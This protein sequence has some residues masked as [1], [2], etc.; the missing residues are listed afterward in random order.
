ME[1]YNINILLKELNVSENTI[2]NWIKF[3]DIEYDDDKKILSLNDY[4]KIK[5]Y[6]KNNKLKSRANKL[7]KNEH[8][9]ND[10]TDIINKKLNDNDINNIGVF[11]ENSLSNSYKNKEGIYYTPNDII[12]DF[13]IIDEDI[14][15]KKFCDPCCGSGNFIMKA[16]SLGFKPENIYG[17]DIDPIA[18]DITKKRILLET[19]YNSENIKCENFLYNEES[20]EFDYI[21]TNPPWGK[22]ISKDEKN[23][24]NKKFNINANDTCVMFYFVILQRLKE[25]GKLGLILPDSF[26]N[27]GSFRNARE[28]ILKYD[29]TSLKHYGQPFEELA[30]VGCVGFTLIKNEKYNEY[31]NCEYNKNKF[32][33]TR[34]SF[35]KNPKTIFNLN[36]KNE[37][38]DIIEYIL[39]RDDYITLEN[40]A[41]WGLGIMTGN[42]NKFITEKED[43]GYTPIF[44]GCDLEKDNIKP[45]SRYILNDLSKCQQVAPIDMYM[46][47]EKII[48]KFIS[49]DLC[50]FYDDRQRLILN[51]ANMMIPDDNFPISNKNLTKLLNCNFMNWLFK[52]IF[53]THKILRG[54]IESLPIFPQYIN[55]EFDEEEYLLGLGIRY[56]DGKYI[57]K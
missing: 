43:N 17:Y 32:I 42:N 51:S 9:H 4:N 27:I 34:N 38:A 49:S 12:N 24:I 23:I 47:K 57:I 1:I 28:S 30:F 10:L 36:V 31:I 14:S 41:R 29:V 16:L 18:V 2:K 15:D 21:Y 22:K 25:G 33:R 54:D 6:G 7:L 44:R 20:I 45:C 48:Y 13:F 55:D 26:F 3:L 46:A 11:Y 52:S 56:V 37:E 5:E 8:N 39:S 19:G 40:N 53:N 50:F 35:I